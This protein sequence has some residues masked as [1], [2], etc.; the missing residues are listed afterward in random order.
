VSRRGKERRGGWRGA[1]G[2]G[3]EVERRAKESCRGSSSS[4]PPP[5]FS[6]HH[7]LLCC[8]CRCMSKV[9]DGDGTQ[10]ARGKARSHARGKRQGTE[11]CER[12]TTPKRPTPC[13]AC[14]LFEWAQ[15]AH[16]IAP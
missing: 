16:S 9:T 5:A 8:C 4:E 6:L 10:E 12:P 13:L 7:L 15:E 14:C 1:R 3:A 2:R 11:A